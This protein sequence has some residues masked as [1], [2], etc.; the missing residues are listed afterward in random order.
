MAAAERAW[1]D[2]RERLY[3]CIFPLLCVRAKNR[4]SS[5]PQQ[6]SAT[7][8]AFFAYAACSRSSF[9]RSC[10]RAFSSTRAAISANLRAWSSPEGLRR[11]AIVGLGFAAPAAA[12]CLLAAQD[13]VFAAG[14]A[15]CLPPLAV[16]AGPRE[17]ASTATL[18]RLGPAAARR[19]AEPARIGPADN[20]GD[21]AW[22]S[23]SRAGVRALCGLPGMPSRKQGRLEPPFLLPCRV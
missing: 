9:F 5:Q 2:H 4:S 11:L 18:P 16:G 1:R 19:G 6:Q 15:F 7:F 17:G 3:S 13:T 20:P 22:S 8:P 10:V 23:V 12:R 14:A 21:V